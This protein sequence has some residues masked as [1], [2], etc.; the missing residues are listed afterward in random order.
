[1]N[2]TIICPA[3]GDGTLLEV[4]EVV[5]GIKMVYSVCS[6]CKSE[7]ADADQARLN[8]ISKLSSEE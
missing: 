1:M 8:K 2:K 7:L 3:C 4:T 5:N 6:H